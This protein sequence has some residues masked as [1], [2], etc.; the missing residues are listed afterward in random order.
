MQNLLITCLLLVASSVS[1]AAQ[2]G[3]NAIKNIKIYD[4]G[5]IFDPPYDTMGMFI[6]VKTKAGRYVELSVRGIVDQTPNAISPLRVEFSDFQDSYFEDKVL[7]SYLDVSTIS[8]DVTCKQSNLAKV[9]K[10]H[11]SHLCDYFVINFK[12][13]DKTYSIQYSER[14]LPFTFTK[15]RTENADLSEE[16]NF[17]SSL[18]ELFHLPKDLPYG[19]YKH[20]RSLIVGYT[21][22]DSIPLAFH[23]VNLGIQGLADDNSELK[24][25]E[26]PNK[27]NKREYCKVLESS[28]ISEIRHDSEGNLTGATIRFT[29]K[30]QGAILNIGN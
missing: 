18:E 10:R 23:I 9:V 16:S 24:N 28:K 19:V 2:T 14:Y 6:E 3:V 22:L 8:A 15:T 7:T 29:D 11:V 1:F 21:S 27:I 4:G 30:N 17:F 5:G 12:I 25:I 13:D 20:D 26:C